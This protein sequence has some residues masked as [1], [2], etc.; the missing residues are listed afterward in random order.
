MGVKW[1]DGAKVQ[2]LKSE[3]EA[4]R[5]KGGGSVDDFAMK[6]MMI[7]TGIRLLGKKVEEV[8]VVKKLFRV[9]PS[10]FMQIVTSIK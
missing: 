3:F 8:S 9:V 2:T 5:I 1:V 10:K 6:L 4:I 7:V